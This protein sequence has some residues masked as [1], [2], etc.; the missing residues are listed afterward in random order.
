MAFTPPNQNPSSYSAAIISFSSKSFCNKSSVSA[1]C[2]SFSFLNSMGAALSDCPLITSDK[3]YMV[4]VVAEGKDVFVSN[5]LILMI[6]C[7]IFIFCFLN[8]EL[9]SS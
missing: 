5:S 7:L 9:D 1:V 4:A 6:F 2:T 8:R 3:S